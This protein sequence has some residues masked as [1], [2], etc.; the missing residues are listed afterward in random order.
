MI[1]RRRD[2]LWLVVFFLCACA[3]RA[4]LS[5]PSS[6]SLQQPI[7][8]VTFENATSEPIIERQ[9][10]ALLKETFTRRGLNIVSPQEGAFLLTGTISQLE[11]TPRSL[12]PEGEARQYRM[13]LGIEYFLYTSGKEKLLFSW[14]ETADA[15]WEA[16]ND[17]TRERSAYDRAI[18]EIS[19]DLAQRALDRLI[20]YLN[21]PVR[22]DTHP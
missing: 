4:P 5:H 21:N 17:F 10:T 6:S 20:A 7:A 3:P 11:R 13:T 8:I 9:V 16:D 2:T 19:R 22:H 18:R 12:G 15:D 1:L 14:K